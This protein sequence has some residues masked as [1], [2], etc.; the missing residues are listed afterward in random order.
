MIVDEITLKWVRSIFKA[1]RGIVL[2]TDPPIAS[3]CKMADRTAS[4]YIS[5]TGVATHCK[6][7]GR[8]MGYS[9]RFFNSSTLY[10]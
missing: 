7:K 10:L 4:A 6:I 2:E 5:L 3:A 8:K 9:F 1:G